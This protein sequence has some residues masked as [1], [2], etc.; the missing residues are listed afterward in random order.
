MHSLIVANSSVYF[1]DRL[2]N[3]VLTASPGIRL[4]KLATTD[5]VGLT[6]TPRILGETLR[7]FYAGWLAPKLLDFCNVTDLENEIC[8]YCLWL[9]STR[10]ILNEINNYFCNCSQHKITN[11][12]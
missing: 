12:F 2:F 5:M 10:A 7:Y 11:Y 4:V 6:V 9:L 1:R 3:G 8:D